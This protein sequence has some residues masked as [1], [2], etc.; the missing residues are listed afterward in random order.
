MGVSWGT[1]IYGWFMMEHPSKMDD[2][3]APYFFL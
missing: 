1:P 3:G 2:L